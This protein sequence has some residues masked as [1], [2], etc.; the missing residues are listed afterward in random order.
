MNSLELYEKKLLNDEEFPI[1]LGVDRVKGKKCYFPLHWH[2]HLELHYVMEGMTSLQTNQTCLKA[3]KGDLVIINSN[4]LHQGTSETMRMD[5]CVIIFEL[6]AFSRELANRNLIFQPLIQNDDRVK[7]L[8]LAIYKENEERLPGYKLSVKGLIF[9]LITYLVRNYVKVSLT[10]SENSKRKKNLDRLNTVIQFMEKNYAED[11]SNAQMARLIHISEG[12]FNHL[13]KEGM[14]MSPL[15]YLN[16][17]RLKKA[18][19]LLEQK[20]YT[21]SEIAIAVGFKDFNHFGRLFR[22]CYQC[23]PSSVM[24]QR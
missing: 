24:K 5:A 19:K 7:E 13:F 2:E 11:I 1:Q 22:K 6:D 18:K 14:G 10:E 16:E 9:Q 3:G 23:T 8:M 21:V 20:E 15:H 4:E 12:R 17:I